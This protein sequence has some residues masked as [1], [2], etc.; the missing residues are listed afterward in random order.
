MQKETKQIPNQNSCH[1]LIIKTLKNKNS[2]GQVQHFLNLLASPITYP[3]S[4][5]INKS[6]NIGIVT[7]LMKKAKAIPIYKAKYHFFPKLSSHFIAGI[8]VK[9]IRQNYTQN[10]NI[11]H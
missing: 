7:D 8:N 2:A 9:T 11:F 4:L 6:I 3:I 5:I 10:T 1:Q